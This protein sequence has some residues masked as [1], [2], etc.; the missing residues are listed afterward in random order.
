MNAGIVKTQLEADAASRLSIGDI[1]VRSF[2]TFIKHP[3][4]FL[5]LCM[6]AQIP[7]IAAIN[8]MQNKPRALMG[9]S[10]GELTEPVMSFVFGLVIQGAIAYG[11]YE[12]LRG[13]SARFDKSLFRGMARIGILIVAALSYSVTI[14][15]MVL[16]FSLF[17]LRLL[18]WPSGLFAFVLFNCNSCLSPT[19]SV[20][21]RK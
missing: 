11:V 9:Y 5:G 13:N 3:F 19:L 20:G 7:G 16:T 12:S 2:F 18:D 8:F 17:L 10:T 21:E 1:L 6:L 4:V 15:V 14:I